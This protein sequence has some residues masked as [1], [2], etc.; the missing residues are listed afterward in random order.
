MGKSFSNRG[1]TLKKILLISY[2]FE[3][4]QA[5][6]S[7]RWSELF[8]LFSN[9]KDY[10]ITLL[11]ANWEGKKVE[12]K[13]VNYIGD[14]I[15]FVPF[16]SINRKFTFIDILKHPSIF[17]RS[18]DRSIFQDQ[19]YLNVKKWIDTNKDN[20]YDIVI[21][22]YTPINAIRLGSYAR[23]VFNSKYIVDMR[24]MMSLQG[25]KIQVPIIDFFDRLL[26]KYW[27]KDA[28]FL[29]SV[30]PTICEKALKFYKKDVHLLY[31]AFLEK[32]FTEKNIDIIGNKIVLSYMGTMGIKRNPRGLLELLNEYAKQ[33]NEIQIEVNF[34]SQ[35]NPHEFIRDLEI[36][37]IKINWL[38]YLSKEGI[39]NLKAETNCFILLEDIDIKGKENV[40]GKVFE[41]MLEQKPVLAYCNQESDIKKI[42]E[43][44]TIGKII[45]DFDNLNLFMDL[46]I[47]NQFMVNKNKI[48]EFSRE[49]QYQKLKGFL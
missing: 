22:S 25:Q 32:D 6:G 41:Y 18:L 35:D 36:N 2:Y 33:N 9:D 7:K 21:A 26:D 14:S 24:D 11:T 43:Y 19:W 16:K 38:G 27:L 20:E 29:L 1:A 5:I 3:P 39:A 30:G 48:L 12:Q 8:S 45:T 42:L 13:N 44:S 28:S 34:A 15:K 47:N 46:I 23:K 49:K 40:T 17:I 31:N 4:C 37:S 10:E